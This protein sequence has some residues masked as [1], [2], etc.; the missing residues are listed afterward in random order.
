M[1]KTVAE[2]NL[3][4][5]VVDKY[6][7]KVAQEEIISDVAKKIRKMSRQ[8]AE[9]IVANLDITLYIKPKDNTLGMTARKKI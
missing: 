5:S 9:E 4:Y 1:I 3:F 6:M 2:N 7:F 8:M